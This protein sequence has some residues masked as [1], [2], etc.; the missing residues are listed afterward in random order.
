MAAN[1]YAPGSD[2][3]PMKT[4][5]S[6]NLASNRA[7]D[8][9]SPGGASS[10]SGGQGRQTLQKQPSGVAEEGFLGRKRFSKR[11]SKSGLAAVF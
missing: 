2:D 6:G 8:L 4:L 1:S 10:N 9:D 7:M 11:Q 3:D 5:N